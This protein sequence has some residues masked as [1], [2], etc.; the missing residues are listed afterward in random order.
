MYFICLN[1]EK[2]KSL[3]TAFPSN[4]WVAKYITNNDCKEENPKKMTL[5]ATCSL[6]IQ[7]YTKILYIIINSKV[8]TLAIL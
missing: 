3:R 5:L 4:W 6:L 2:T 8:Q 1:C 7:N